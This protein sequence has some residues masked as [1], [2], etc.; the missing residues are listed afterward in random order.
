MT[1]KSDTALCE[2]DRVLVR[3]MTERGGPGKLRSYWEQEIYVVTQKR[4]DMPVY[5]VK[6]ETGNGRSRVLHRNLLLPCSYLPVETQ[7][8][9][10]KSRRAVSRKTNK[11]QASQEE[12]TRT[13]DEDFTSLTP[14]QLQEF[15]QCTGYPELAERDAGTGTA[16]DSYQVDGPGSE[17]EVEDPEQLDNMVEDEA[18]DGLPLRQSQRL[19][20]PPLRMTYYVIGQPSFQP[21]SIAGIQGISI[22]STAVMATCYSTMDAATSPASLQLFCTLSGTSSANVS[23]LVLLAD[24]VKLA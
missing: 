24:L 15:Y 21:N 13:T 18:A 9:S 11:Q 4:K 3:N 10:S 23:Y 17:G 14:Y 16:Q 7:L 5:E 2:G 20:R 6:P 8:K 12:I 19:R 1:R 22:I